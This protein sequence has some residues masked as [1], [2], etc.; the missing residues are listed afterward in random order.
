METL[1]FEELLPEKEGLLNVDVKIGHVSI[2]PH[3]GRTVSVT[4]EIENSTVTVTREGSTIYVTSR[5]EK[6][7]TSN[8]SLF[9]RLFQSGFNSKAFLTIYVPADCEIKARTTT[10]ELF[11]SGIDAPVTA[12][13]TTGKAKLSDIGGPIYAKLITGK[14]TYN[15]ILANSDHRFEAVTGSINLRL[16]KEPNA[17]LDASTATGSIHCGFAL[18]KANRN[19]HF[20][21]SRLRGIL[22]SGDGHI[23]AVVT[24]GELRLE[25]A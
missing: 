14:L 20:T 11:V 8:P 22:G 25:H 19:R 7:Q 15:G 18:S 1:F 17:Q 4:A 23:K 16:H 24:T 10:G 12:R 2:Q 5:P 21:G 6:N 13:V 3:D 9:N